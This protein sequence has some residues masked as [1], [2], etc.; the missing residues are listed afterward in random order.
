[1]NRNLEQLNHFTFRLIEGALLDKCPIFFLETINYFDK[2]P[3]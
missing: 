2:E 1:M 3:F